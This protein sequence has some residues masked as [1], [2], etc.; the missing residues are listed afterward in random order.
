MCFHTYL[1]L[2]AVLHY[3]LL[4]CSA[5]RRSYPDAVRLGGDN[6]QSDAPGHETGDSSNAVKKATL[7]YH[8]KSGSLDPHNDWIAVRAGI[9]ET[10]FRLDEQ[11]EMKPWLAEKW[12]NKD[13]RTWVFTLRE[14]I[15]FHDGTKL[16]AE[17]SQILYNQ[18]KPLFQE[19]KVRKAMD[20]LLDRQSIAKDI[21]LGYATAAISLILH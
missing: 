2:Y 21:M 16:D 12:E 3:F 8:F 1:S 5:L 17:G 11:L 10:L 19:V 18:Q 14:G 6:N 13:E 4:C 15:T 7:I 9:A 20:L